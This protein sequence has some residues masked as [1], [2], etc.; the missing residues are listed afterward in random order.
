MKKIQ[1]SN[2]SGCT[3]IEANAIESVLEHAKSGDTLV[4]FDIDNTLVHT[5]QEL[6]GDTWAYWFVQQKLKEGLPLNQALDYMF[7]LLKHVHT[8]IDVYPVEGRSVGIVQELKELEVPTICLTGRPAAMI[9]ITQEQL[10][11][12]GFIFN[13]PDDL[14]KAMTLKMDYPVEMANGIICGGIN[15]KG[16][17]LSHIFQTLQC[18]VP[19]AVVFVDDKKSC[20]ESIGKT[21]ASREID[22]TGLRYGY[23]DHLAEQ[24]D[25]KKAEEQLT[26]LLNKHIFTR[27][28]NWS[29]QRIIGEHKII[30]N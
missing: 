1:Q 30:R 26:S 16:H 19:Q 11:K 5:N 20:V 21:C 4:I 25:A 22:Y 2:R 9:D 7:D 6:G 24:F 13:S 29:D 23:L 27:A 18:Q 28:N 14:N 15:D 12:V 17:V 8:H 10:K 3:I